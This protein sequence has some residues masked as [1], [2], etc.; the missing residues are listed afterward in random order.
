MPIRLLKFDQHGEGITL[1]ERSQ[2]MECISAEIIA[3]SESGKDWNPYETLDFEEYA[4]LSHTWLSKGEITYFDWKDPNSLDTT[5]PGYN[6]LAKFCKT[7]SDQGLRLGWMDTVCI[8]KENSTELDESIRSMFKW[9][10]NAQV[11]IVYLAETESLEDMKSD[12]WFTR[13]WTLQELLA[14]EQMKFY[15]KHWEFL[16]AKNLNIELRGSNFSNDLL[17]S[18]I[19]AATGLEEEEL[20]CCPYYNDSVPIWRKMQW[21]ANQNVTR[22]EDTA[23]SLMGILACQQAMVR[24]W[25]THSCVS[26]GKF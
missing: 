9:Y 15:A 12:K 11:C 3:K 22:E 14:P 26:S 25:T 7:A 21:A 19:C 18:E 13:G 4:I 23:Y 20:S 5:S 8:N 17:S 16:G 2:V 6:K 10:Q 24:V 1:V